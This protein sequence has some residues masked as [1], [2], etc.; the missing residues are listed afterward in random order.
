M[1]AY[2]IL[3]VYIL[4]L[5]CVT[6]KGTVLYT[7]GNVKSE[8]SNFFLL[9][10]F[11]AAFLLSALRN[12]AV[13]VDTVN[14]IKYYKAVQELSWGDLIKGEWDHHFFTTEK[15]FMILEKICG[16]LMLPTQLFI[17]LCA[18][19]FVYGIYKLVSAYIE[20]NVVVSAFSF[21]AVGSYLLSINVLRQGIGVGLCCIAWVEL[22]KGNWKRFVIGVLLACTFHVSCC[23]FFLAFIFE[24]IPAGR[25]SIIIST[26]VMMVFG[27]VGA[28]VLPIILRWFP[29][30]VVRYGNGRWKINAANGIVVVWVVVLAIILLSAFR[31]DWSKKEY[32]IDFEVMLFSLCYVSI[33]IIGLSFDGAQRLSMLFQPF[34]ILLFSKSCGLWGGATKSIY[35][36]GVVAGMIVLFLKAASTAQYAYLPFWA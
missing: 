14:Y 24:K 5:W 2:I 21:L 19:I 28:T 34:L 12:K 31:L 25:K 11:L 1:S 18:G 27:F 16:D 6:K 32:H 13:G 7:V 22:K 9:M 4:L 36:T 15:G 29:V 17:A 23:V 33:N 3:I 10:S 20:S 26:I 35:T 8:G 30:Y